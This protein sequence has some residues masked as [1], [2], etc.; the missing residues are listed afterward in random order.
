M[1]VVESET[2]NILMQISPLVSSAQ[3]SYFHL[4]K[5]L[6]IKFTVLVK[7]LVIHKTYSNN[8]GTAQKVHRVE[9]LDIM[10]RV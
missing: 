10:W 1:K 4:W 2:D 5:I 7:T 3:T 9:L 8:H 6:E